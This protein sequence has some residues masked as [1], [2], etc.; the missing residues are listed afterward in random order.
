MDCQENKDYKE[1]GK[2]AEEKQ[3][4]GALRL[5]KTRQEIRPIRLRLE[6]VYHPQNKEKMDDRIYHGLKTW[7]DVTYGDT[8]S[9]DVIVPSDMPLWA[10]NY[11]IQRCFGWQNSHLHQ[12]EL[13]PEQFKR[14]LR[15]KSDDGC[16]LTTGRYMELVGVVFRSPWMEEE[17]EFW[18]E[19]YRSGSIKT[20]QRKK[21]TGP[22]RSLCAGEEIWQCRMDME[23]LRDQFA[24]VE[25]EHDFVG[26]MECF[27]Y[28]RPISQ[29]MYEKKR[30]KTPLMQEKEM[31]ERKIQFRQ[32]VYALEDL[33]IEAFLNLS[34]RSCV[35]LLERLKIGEILAL[36]GQRIQDELAR[37]VRIPCCFE[38]VMD[39]RL[40]EEIKECIRCNSTDQQ[41]KLQTLTDTLYY[42]YD[43]GEDWYVKISASAG[44]L[45]LIET[46]RVSQ[47]ELEKATLTMLTTH[48]PVCIAQDGYSVLDDVG[49]IDGYVQFLEEIH[50][51]QNAEST[52]NIQLWAESM[53]WKRRRV[54]NQRML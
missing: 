40:R 52:T 34:E 47:D 18:N 31:H 43:F 37:D 12:F 6:L 21:Y 9:R 28:P 41:P 11:M 38:D 10:L 33:P 15:E 5:P 49:G 4:L 45:D 1:K 36:H 7:G 23:E 14:I 3:N 8:I 17:E 22:Y 48:R 26:E 30:G 19:D 53:G 29:K 42:H 13:P 20:W 35:S 27:G 39:E 54:S 25:V 32:E 16:K 24:Y 51:E 46:G 44:A 2:T 50:Q